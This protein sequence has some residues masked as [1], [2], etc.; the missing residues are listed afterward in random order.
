[1]STTYISRQTATACGYRDDV[2]SITVQDETVSIIELTDLQIWSLTR[3]CRRYEVPFNPAHFGTAFDL[4]KGWVSG[5]V[6]GVYVG[7]SPEGDIHS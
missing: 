2:H 4:P 6:G 5:F 1:M 7:C 3:L